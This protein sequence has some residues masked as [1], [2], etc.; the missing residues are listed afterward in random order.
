MA[1]LSKSNNTQYAYLSQL[2]VDELM[3]LLVNAPDRKSVV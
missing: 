3:E 2:S 1:D